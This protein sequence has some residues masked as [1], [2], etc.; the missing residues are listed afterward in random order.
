MASGPDYT[1]FD[2]FTPGTQARLNFVERDGVNEQLVDVLRTPGKQVIVYGETGS[3]KSTLL[4]N[5]LDQLYENHVTTRCHQSMSFDQILLDAFDQLAP[6]YEEGGRYAIEQTTRSSLGADFRAIR[7]SLDMSAST[8]SETSLA[9]VLPPQLTPQ[10]LGQFLGSRKICWVIEDFHKV[11]DEVKTPLAQA[12]KVFCDLAR[13]YREVKIV[14]IGATDTAR[15]VIEYDPE[16]ANRVAE[17]MVPLMSDSEVEEILTGGEALLNVDFGRSKELVV[18][19]SVGVSEHLPSTRVEHVHFAR[20]AVTRDRDRTFRGFRPPDRPQ[21]VHPAAVG[22][23]QI[24]LR[25]SP[26]RK[27][28]KKYDNCR[29]ILEALATAPPSGMLHGEILAKIRERHA[30]Y[31]AGNLTS[32][33]R[34]LQ[35]E[36]RG[37]VVRSLGANRYGFIDPFHQLY[38]HLTLSDAATSSNVLQFGSALLD[39][40]TAELE[41]SVDLLFQRLS[42]EAPGGRTSSR[43]ITRQLP[44]FPSEDR[45]KRRP[46]TEP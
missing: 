8:T 15:E 23:A 35:E 26:V 13:D 14:A 43:S 18:A 4:Q 36:D 10:R 46:P 41:R 40:L 24:S 42:S 12:L 17:I 25:S 7:A 9:R 1:V 34:A 19:Y 21:K 29:L 5:K 30:Q 31:P 39:E 44:L 37:A 27:Q 6:Y 45:P 32:Y 33:L 22:H 3:G 16:M 28:V 2:V 11:A 20:C 38:C